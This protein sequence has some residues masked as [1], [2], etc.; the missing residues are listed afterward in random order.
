MEQ[1]I[2]EHINPGLGAFV[3]ADFSMHDPDVL[4]AGLRAAGLRVAGF[5]GI[6]STEYVARFMLPGPAEF[7]WNYINL[8]PMGPLVARAPDSAKEAMERDVVE[9]WRPHVVHGRMPVDQPMALAWGRR[10]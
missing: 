10:A 1:A 8:T 9:A 3:S 7:V 4:A 6:G 2:V 5:A